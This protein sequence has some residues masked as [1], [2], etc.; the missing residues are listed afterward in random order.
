MADGNRRAR[1]AAVPSPAASIA[2][3]PPPSPTPVA[4]DPAWVTEAHE[5]L[6][7]VHPTA[8]ALELEP[9]HVLGLGTSTLSYS[10]LEA[11]EEVHREL[12]SRLADARIELVREQERT[13]A[14]ELAEI[15]RLRRALADARAR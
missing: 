8:V 11:A 10:Q 5:R 7:R 9:R 14:E 3:P 15:D 6:A 1:K 2:A 12:L 13:R 4:P